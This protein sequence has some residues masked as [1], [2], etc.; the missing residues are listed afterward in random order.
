MPHHQTTFRRVDTMPAKKKGARK[1]TKRGGRKT[2]KRK[3]SKR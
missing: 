2:T 3:S 1:G